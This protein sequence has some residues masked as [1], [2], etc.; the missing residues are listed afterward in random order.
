MRKLLDINTWLALSLEDHPQHARARRW[1]EQT[2]LPVGALLFCRQTE[3]GFLRLVTQARVMERCGL[4]AL[5]NTAALE[6]LA[7]VSADPVVAR[8]EKPP[9]TRSL[10]LQIARS[11]LPSPNVWMDA[12]LAAFAI[13]LDAEMIPFDRDFKT[14]ERHGLKLNLLSGTL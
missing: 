10:W 12:Y 3:I 13:A 14:H 7:K 2:P 6:F 11:P 4:H 9:A 1:Y 8:A 5:S